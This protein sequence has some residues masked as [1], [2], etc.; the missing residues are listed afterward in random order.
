MAIPPTR[1]NPKPLGLVGG[2]PAGFPNGR[3]V[4]DDVVTIELRAIAGAT[5]PLVEQ[6]LH[7]GR[8]RRARDRWA[9][10]G[11]HE[12]PAALPVPRDAQE[13][14]RGEAAGRLNAAHPPAAAGSLA[15]QEV[16]RAT[17]TGDDR[18]REA[19][20][21]GLLGDHH[22]A[23][24]VQAARHADRG[25]PVR[26]GAEQRAGRRRLARCRAAPTSRRCAPR[27]AGAGGGRSGRRARRRSAARRCRRS[28]GSPA[29]RSSRRSTS[30]T[31][32]ITATTTAAS[33]P[34]HANENRVGARTV[35]GR[36]A[37]AGFGVARTSRM[38]RRRRLA[39]HLAARRPRAAARR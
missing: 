39:R 35:R 30:A 18:G 22:R 19:P 6:E 12:V 31:A 15:T 9:G 11:E 16:T 34:P 28:P 26:T 2:D 17:I 36:P 24:P 23:D 3:R 32:T 20:P 21:G 33:A 29:C 1:K 4:F 14:V 8:G 13:R 25:R 10:A 37:G 38:T 7:A 27:A 5:Y